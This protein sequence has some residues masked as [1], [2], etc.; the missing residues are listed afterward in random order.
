MLFCR[1]NRYSP[2]LCKTGR[3]I[4]HSEVRADKYAIRTTI[5]IADSQI[6]FEIVAIDLLMLDIPHNSD[7]ISGVTCIRPNDM[8]AT[9]LIDN[10]FR[11]ADKAYLNRDILDLVLM[12]PTQDMMSAG[13]KKAVL[14][15]GTQ[16]I[17]VLEQQAHGLL[18]NS[19]WLKECISRLD[20]DIS[21]VLCQSK[22]R[23]FLKLVKNHTNE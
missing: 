18:L 17:D 12:L 19:T 9:K 14:A 16:V 5:L 2:P 11:G 13:L 10:L 6:K 4:Q 1:G 8:V 3:S 21:P 20:I 22:I 23:Q 7:M 15:Q